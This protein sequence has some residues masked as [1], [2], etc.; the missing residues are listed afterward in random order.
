MYLIERYIISGIGRLVMLIPGFLIFMFACYSSQRYLTE[1][2]NGTLALNVVFDVVFYKVIIALEMLLPIGLYVS[3]A[4]ALGQLYNDSEITALFSSGGSPRKIYNS[5]LVLALPLGIVVTLLSL[6]GRPWAYTKIYQ[7][8]QQSQSKLDVSNFQANKFNTSDDGRMV[9][10]ARIDKGKGHL[11]DALIYTPSAGKTSLYRARFVDVIDPSPSN[12]SVMLHSG[13]SY[14]LDQTGTDD[15]KQTFDN[16]KMNLKPIVQDTEVRRKSAPIAQLAHST[17]LADIAELQW[18]QSRGITA[19]LMALLAIFLSKSK[20]RQGRFATL[21]P[22]TIMFTAIY[23]GGN[24]TRTL[25]ANG[26]LPAMPGLWVVPLIMLI[27]VLL[28]I[29]Q[30]LSLFKKLLR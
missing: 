16:L 15:K 7:L 2:A 19:V 13:T 24:L 5:V 20:P 18:R 1:A 26:T 6:Y 12:P 21:L 29:A 9:L 11:T 4:V 23:Y 14:S 27:A 30:D 28:F 22:L 3:I 25:V 8:E 10:A 17:D